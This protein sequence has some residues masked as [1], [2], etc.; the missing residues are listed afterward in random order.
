MEDESGSVAARNSFSASA[1]SAAVVMGAAAPAMAAEAVSEHQPE[2]TPSRAE[3]PSGPGAAPDEAEERRLL[4]V[5]MTRARSRLLLSCAALRTRY[6]A[7]R[8]AGLDNRPS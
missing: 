8:P 4:F 5:G 1:S 3:E 6:G 2:D 7:S